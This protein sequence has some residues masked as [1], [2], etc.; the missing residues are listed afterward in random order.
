MTRG[1]PSREDLEFATRDL[2]MVANEYEKA[3]D[4]IK[5]LEEWRDRRK[6]GNLPSIPGLSKEIARLKTRL[7]CF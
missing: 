7:R 2:K 3:R 6:R 1:N 5:K 4:E